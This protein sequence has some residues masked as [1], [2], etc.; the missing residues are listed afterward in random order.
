MSVNQTLTISEHR[1][2]FEHIKNN[3]IEAAANIMS[4]H[5]TGVL[6]FAKNQQIII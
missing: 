2:L 6:T 3:D 4:Q 5:L 1:L